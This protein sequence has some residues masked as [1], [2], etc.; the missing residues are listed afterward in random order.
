MYLL[1]STTAVAC[2]CHQSIYVI[3]GCLSTVSYV[4]F[5][6]LSKCPAGTVGPLYLFTSFVTSLASFPSLSLLSSLNSF[7]PLFLFFLLSVS[8]SQ[9][10][11]STQPSILP[12]S[13][14]PNKPLALTLHQRACLLSDNLGR[15]SQRYPLG[16]R[17]YLSFQ[18]RT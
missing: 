5:T 15:V 14:L 11:T 9:V 1:A 4:T 3:T 10:P 17:F 12:L 6:A 16:L 2:L 7:F 8:S 18:E 13:P